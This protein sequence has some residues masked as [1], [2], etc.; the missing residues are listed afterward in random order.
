M[1]V[2]IGNG[3]YACGSFDVLAVLHD[4]RTGRFHAAVL[5]EDPPPGEPKPLEQVEVV[6]LRTRMH[7]TAGADTLEGACEHLR[8]IHKQIHVLDTN[9]WFDKVFE[10]DGGHGAMVLVKNWLRSAQPN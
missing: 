8:E 6:R 7:H 1:F 2:A 5:V 9:I 3:Q 4:Q 10:W